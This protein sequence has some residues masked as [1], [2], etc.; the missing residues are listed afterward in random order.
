[1]K[2]PSGNLLVGMSL[3]ISLLFVCAGILLYRQ[4]VQTPVVLPEPPLK[5]LAARHGI[6]LG[7]FAILT[8]LK[9]PNY[10]HILSTQYNVA[11]IDN[12]PNWYFTDGGMRPSPTTY[13]FHNM[14]T[15]VAYAQQH[16]MTMQAHHLLW[17]EEKWLPPWL[18]DH[19]YTHDQYMSFIH[20]HISNV[21]GRYAGQIQ[22]WTVV[23]EAFTRGQHKF[24]LSDWW[25][26]HTGGGTG[27]I[28]QAF[29]WAHE[30]D[31][32]AKLILNDFG[33]EAENSVSDAMYVY[34]KSAKARGVPI[35]G[36][37]MQMHIDANS[38]PKKEAVIKNMQRFAAIG[39]SIY[40][41]EFDVNM[42][43][44]FAPQS[45]RM[46][47]EATIY[48]DMMR[49]CIESKVCHSFS[50][51]GITDAETWYNYMGPTSAN[52][53]PLMFDKQYRPKPAFDA[54]RDAL[55]EQ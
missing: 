24:G 54:F 25:A 3:G 7:N 35:D 38:V 8:H 10:D 27:Y 13:D 11:L 22:Q 53:A 37:G 48:H 47:K 20:D 46:E 33:N 6:E 45:V 14:D 30:A 2:R 19:A 17:G 18:K 9:D 44:V 50:Q 16:K 4:Q 40:V 55:L 34:I 12:T 52:A 32:N 41:T 31:P 51:L 28:D 1:M 29:I 15:V 49:A 42:S 23:N 39:V 36:L 21:A 26:D 5:D 43:G